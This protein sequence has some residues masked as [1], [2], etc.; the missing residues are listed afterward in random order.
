MC[1]GEP[2][3]LTALGT[4]LTHEWTAPNG[5]LLPGDVLSFSQSA[6]SDAGIYLLTALN[7]FGCSDQDSFELI[8]HSLP[9]FTLSQTDPLCAEG[10]Y[11]LSPGSGYALYNWSNGLAD[12]AITATGEGIFWVEVTD[13]NGCKASFL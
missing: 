6:T 10:T 7:S 8:I 3:N 5:S 4:G 13:D 11:T 1:E 9:Q 12:P 2:I